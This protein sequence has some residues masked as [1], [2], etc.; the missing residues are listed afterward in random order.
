L[1][2]A[3]DGPD[4]LYLVFITLGTQMQSHDASGRLYCQLQRL[5]PLHTDWCERQLECQLLCTAP[6]AHAAA[7]NTIA[8]VRKLDGALLLRVE[9]GL[10]GYPAPQVVLTCETAPVTEP[11][12]R[13][14]DGP[15]AAL[16]A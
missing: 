3:L 2:G 12:D 13:D 14:D 4:L 8:C 7:W 10:P 11:E 9:A 5:V 6:S 16:C 15:E 1:I